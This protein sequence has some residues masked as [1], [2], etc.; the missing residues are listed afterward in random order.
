MNSKAG[1]ENID[2]LRFSAP[3]PVRTWIF[4]H[5]IE[6]DFFVDTTMPTFG[7]RRDNGDLINLPY[8]TGTIDFSSTPPFLWIFTCFVPC[9]FSY[10][11]VFHDEGYK[12]HYLVI[13]G[14][15]TP[16]SRL[17]MDKLL[18]EMI[19]LEPDPGTKL[20]AWSYLKGVRWFGWLYW[21]SGDKPVEPVQKLDVSKYVLPS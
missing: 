7:F 13:N 15:K 2:K 19:P 4:W 5:R 1:F 18:N 14:S 21:G 17:F 16:V 20:E 12:H 8:I 10:S 9:R 6:I 3:R 11:A